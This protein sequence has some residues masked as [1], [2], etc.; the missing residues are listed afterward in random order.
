MGGKIGKTKLTEIPRMGSQTSIPRPLG[1][2]DKGPGLPVHGGY[3]QS[4]FRRSP[5]PFVSPTP[6]KV[7]PPSA[8]V[9]SH[10]SESASTPRSPKFNVGAHM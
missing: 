6:G 10:F 5:K 2:R 9:M 8:K 4:T 3:F 1:K 7:A